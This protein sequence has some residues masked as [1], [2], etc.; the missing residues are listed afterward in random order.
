MCFIVSWNPF[1]ILLVDSLD[2]EDTPWPISLFARCGSIRRG[3]SFRRGGCREKKSS[4][5]M[6]LARERTRHEAVDG[7]IVLPPGGFSR[8]YY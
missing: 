3:A 4:R 8:I 2:P 1:F 5:G 7:R 6:G